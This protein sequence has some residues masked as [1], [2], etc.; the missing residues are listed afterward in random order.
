[1]VHRR[2]TQV[3]GIVRRLLRTWRRWGVA[4]VWLVACGDSGSGREGERAVPNAAGGRTGTDAVRVEDF[5]G[6][7][8]CRA[9]HAVQHAAWSGSTH[10]RAGGE[11]GPE[12]V[13][14]P[15][16]GSPIV[17]R[18][19]VVVPETAVGQAGS[20]AAGASRTAAVAYRFVVRQEG[21]PE[22]VYAVDGVVGGGHMV[23]GGTQGY[24]TRAA[25][26]TVRFLPFDWSQALGAW[27]CNTGTRAERGW[28]PVSASMA[29][30]DCGDWPPVRVM[31]DLS[32][33]ANCQSCHGSQVVAERIPGA[34]VST[35]WMSLDVNCESCHGPARHHMEIMTVA[36]PA[37]ADADRP[38]P[39]AAAPVADIGLASRIVDDVD[40]SLETCFQCHAVK[41][42][43][44]EG[45]LP[46]KSFA[47]HYALKLPVLGDDPYLPDG[48]VRTFAYQ[49][50]HLSSSCYVDGAMT[51]VSCH[52]PHGLGY[53][54]ANRRPLE[55]RFDDGQ[56]TA[57]HASK[58]RGP[59]SHTFHPAGSPGSRCVACHMPYLQ[60][61]ETGDAVPFARSDHTI[62]VPRPALD[63]RL[64]LTSACRACHQDRSET[65]LQA[66]V[67]AWW[68]ALKPHDPPVAGLLALTPAMGQAQSARLLLH[69]GDDGSTTRFQAAA[70]FVERWVQPGAPLETIAQDRLALMTESADMELQALALA[71]LHA[72]S[73]AE[74][75]HLATA[76]PARRPEAVRRRWVLVLSFLADRA[77]EQG[78]ADAAAALYQKALEVFPEDPAVWRSLGLVHNRAGNAAAAVQAF[79][80]SLALNPNQPLVHVNQGV[81]LAASGDPAGAEAAYEAALRVD[82]NEP[83]AHFNLGNLR[84]RSGD[85]AGAGR[86]YRQ[87]LALDPG[88]SRAHMNLAVALARGGRWPEA[89]DH[90]RQAVEFAPNDDVPKRVLAD[91]RRASA[92]R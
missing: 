46:G 69:P 20:E 70:R 65:A 12:I 17:F 8:A 91:L 52:E 88:M 14:A 78:D 9:C 22:R 18:D 58:A 2:A 82:P 31:G 62:P 77:A 21:R 72:T 57:C 35:R 28:V 3:N 86:A 1:M 43:V 25:D 75:P 49:G 71:A 39:G 23:G 11:P 36:T 33:F 83:L 45:Y 16:D 4:C 37:P 7:D 73:S 47:D 48:R 68:G 29:L 89:L 41:D 13:L 30:A 6:S 5:A 42:V 92:N 64:G 76:A 84:L 27:F 15:F 61:P 85:E 32:R 67:D 55:G 54:D 60:H 53:W 66:Q 81:A 38:D 50:T 19:A 24:L 74:R 80:R 87:A 26:G 63:G 44:R 90:A 56:C 10:G 79:A 34:G 59:E 51:C 40:R